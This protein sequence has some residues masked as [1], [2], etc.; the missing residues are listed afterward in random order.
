[1]VRSRI[2]AISG[3]WSMMQARRMVEGDV[4]R[5]LVVF[6]GIEAYEDVVGRPGRGDLEAVG[7]QVGGEGLLDDR[8]AVDHLVSGLGGAVQWPT[9][10]T[11]GVF[12][13]VG[14]LVGTQRGQRVER[15]TAGQ[16]AVAQQDPQPVTGADAQER[17]R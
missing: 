15:Y 11:V 2:P 4:V 7:V 1:M 8:M 17:S 12:C 6:E 13:A 5:V 9:C 10:R 3:T 14:G 16:H